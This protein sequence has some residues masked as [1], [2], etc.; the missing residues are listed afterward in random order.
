MAPDTL[1]INP[2]I[3]PAI[4][5]EHR[6]AY[7]VTNDALV[8]REIFDPVRLIAADPDAA[9]GRSLTEL[10][11][12]LVGSEDVLDAIA[13]GRQ[14]RFELEMVNRTDWGGVR[15]S[16]H[17]RL[18]LKPGQDHGGQPHSILFLVEDMTQ[19]GQ[20][21][22]RMMQSRNELLLLKD[23]LDNKNRALV[24]ANLELHKL[25]DMKTTFVSIAAHELRTPLAIIRGYSDMLLDEAFGNLVE[26]QRDALALMRHSTDRLLEIVTNL[27]DLTRLEAGRIELVMQPLDIGALVRAT[28]R[29]F[30]P[31]FDG[32]QQRLVVTAPSDL[33]AALCDETRAFQILGNLLSNA[34]KYTPA[35]GQI[36]LRVGL[37]ATPGELMVS[38]TDNG[39][40][41]PLDEQNRLGTLFFRA[42]TANLTSAHGVGLGLYITTSLVQLHGGRL[43]FD[44]REGE[45][46]TF[47]VTFLLADAAE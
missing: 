23:A 15:G 30:G 11:P 45:G 18:L 35:G 37:A 32:A 47:Y 1:L 36:E 4:M 31:L 25:A 28:A 9:I 41:I 20:M 8:V 13:S 27:L 43:W 17:L 44:S 5:A 2:D 26:P 33:P 29:E 39:V 40:G 22:Q 3:L 34:S 14:A 12:E 24:A 6:L 10:A 42:R 21:Q 7:A 16:L 46:S 38:V 19:V